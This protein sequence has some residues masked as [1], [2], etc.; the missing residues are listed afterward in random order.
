M[1]K[2]IKSNTD[3]LLDYLV[4]FKEK[5][6]MVEKLMLTISDLVETAHKI[7]SDNKDNLVKISDNVDKNKENILINTKKQENLEEMFK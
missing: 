1:A 2:Q 7:I 6:E 3:S 4:A 5:V